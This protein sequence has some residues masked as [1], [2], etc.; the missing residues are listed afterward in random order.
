[1]LTI[2]NNYHIYKHDDYWFAIR[3]AS[4]CKVEVLGMPYIG[5]GGRRT[6]REIFKLI[7]E[8]MEK[9]KKKRQEYEKF[10]NL[11]NYA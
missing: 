4:F 8:D 7:K 9:I 6:K 5:N 11:P 2:K 1:M 3:H 10:K